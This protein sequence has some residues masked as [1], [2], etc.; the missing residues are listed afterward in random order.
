VVL[1]I[2]GIALSASAALRFGF[3]VTGKL[4]SSQQS[5][6]EVAVSYVSEVLAPGESVLY[7]ARLSPVI[8][9]LPALLLAPAS[10]L[11]ALTLFVQRYHFIAPLGIIACCAPV[12]MLTSAWIRRRSTEIA[13]TEKRLIFRRGVVRVDADELWLE[14]IQSVQTIQTTMD[15]LL[16]KGSVIVHESGVGVIQIED[17]G[18]PMSFRRA[19]AAR[20]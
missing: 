13:I 12:W 2:I 4:D 19:L 11:L 14:R 16:R 17:I 5:I 8:F 15:R 10:V 20:Q 7:Q 6:R 1:Q 3:V 9:F 18:D